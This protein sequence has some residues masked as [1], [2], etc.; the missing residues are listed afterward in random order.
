[1][2]KSHRPDRAL[3]VDFGFL[4]HRGLEPFQSPN[5]L[6]DEMQAQPA[7]LRLLGI[8]PDEDCHGTVGILDINV[9]RQ[10]Q[11]RWIGWE[12]NWVLDNFPSIG[13]FRFTGYFI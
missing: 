3:I 10:T 2:D 11:I 7:M 12:Q 13:E 5:F 9:I 1:M 6:W 4:N 8:Q